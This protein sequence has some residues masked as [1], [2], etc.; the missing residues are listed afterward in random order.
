MHAAVQALVV[1]GCVAAGLRLRAAH[2]L[3]LLVGV[4]VLLPSSVQLPNG[5]T[6]LPT[7]TRL[8]ALA[9]AAA[10]VRRHGRGVLRGTPLHTAAGLY[11]GT[12]LLTGVLLA[13]PELSFGST[14]QAW[15][16]LLDPLL[17]GLVAMGCVRAEGPRAVLVALGA[18]GLLAVAAGTVE[19]VTGQP[20]SALLV[21]GEGLERRAGQSRVRVG[22][23]FA[24]AF[25]WTVAALVPAVVA[26]LRRR[27]VLTLLGL[28]G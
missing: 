28:G 21:R 5:V 4:V 7:A 20:L 15:L 18:V 17:V 6:P 14:L 8:T 25:A 27:L 1:A 10:L 3:A 12:V 9:V 2:G 19:H 24:L 26:L 13:G 11:A 22:S 23:D 16:S